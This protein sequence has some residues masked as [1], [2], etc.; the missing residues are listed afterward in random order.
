MN[1][2]KDFRIGKAFYLLEND[3][4]SKLRLSL[5]YAEF[6]YSY[7]VI[8]DRG[9]VDRLKKQAVIIAKDMLGKKAQKNL[10]YKLLQLN[11]KE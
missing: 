2:I 9:R 10:N 8:S 3:K 11:M 7:K 4:G 1:D 5:N 6:S